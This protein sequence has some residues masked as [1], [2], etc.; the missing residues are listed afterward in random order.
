[1]TKPNFDPEKNLDELLKL[2]AEELEQN[3]ESVGENRAVNP[4]KVNSTLILNPRNWK[5]TSTAL[6]WTRKRPWK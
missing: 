3:P 6:W 2:E 1:M 5:S 4:G